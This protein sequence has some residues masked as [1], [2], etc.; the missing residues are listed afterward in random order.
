MWSYKTNNAYIVVHPFEEVTRTVRDVGVVVGGV[1]GSGWTLGSI[2][3]AT[4]VSISITHKDLIKCNSLYI[5]NVC[6][7]QSTK[8]NI[9]PS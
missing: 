3:L 7:T 1:W 5:Y 2:R 4:S 9:V 6:R 8:K